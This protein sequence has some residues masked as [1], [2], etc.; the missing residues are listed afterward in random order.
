MSQDLRS[1][2]DKEQIVDVI[3]RLFLA[4]D[5]RDW[6]AAQA[7]FAESVLF[8]M[9]SA[10]A[11]PSASRTPAQITSGW[12]T[13]L[14]PIEALHH[15]AG[16]F[17][18]QAADDLATASCYGIAYHFRKVQ[19]GRNTRV[20]VGSYDFGLAKDGPRWRI[21]RFRFNLKYVDGNPELEKSA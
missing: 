9:S 12:E 4:T 3:T 19:S 18:V 21:T 1:L 8:D 17:S 11:G 14:A 15:Q 16:N 20:F 7:C 10:G 6:E 5:A 13:G 2:S